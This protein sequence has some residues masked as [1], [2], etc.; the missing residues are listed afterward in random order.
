MSS[1]ASQRMRFACWRASYVQK[2][3]V[4]HIAQLPK[5]LAGSDEREGCWQL[6]Q[7]PED[8]AADK[9]RSLSMI[10]MTLLLNFGLASRL[11]DDCSGGPRNVYRAPALD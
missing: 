4:L 6:E 9:L 10:A 2:T 11:A 3:K 1:R 5:I 7:Q 8:A